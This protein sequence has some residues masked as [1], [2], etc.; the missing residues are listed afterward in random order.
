MILDLYNEGKS[1]IEIAK[2]LKLG[3]GEVRLVIDLY[4]NR[5]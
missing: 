2:Q 4:N 5:K 1:N 3:M